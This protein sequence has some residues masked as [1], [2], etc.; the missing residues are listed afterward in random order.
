MSS[1]PIKV[2]HVHFWGDVRLQAGSVEKVIAAFALMAETD[3]TVSVACPGEGESEQIGSTRFHFFREDRLKNRIANKLLGLNLFT[4]SR[5]ANL[6][7]R[8]RP[9]LLHVHNRHAL[10]PALLARLS[11][12]P[13]VLCHY[14]RKFGTFV[15]PA[16]ADRLIAVSG[17]V[18]DALEEAVHPVMPIDVVYNPLP[19]GLTS[20]PSS[21]RPADLR[22]RLLFGGGRQHNKGFFELEA[23]LADGLA[24]QFDV[25]LCGP[26]FD[27][28]V[29]AFPARVLGLLPSAEFLAELRAADVV[30]MPSHH[31][32]FSILA[33]EA[34]GMGK[35]L[36]ATQGGGLGEIFDEHNAFIHPVGDAVGLAKC[37]TKAL[38]L[39]QADQ[40]ASLAARVL[41]A[42][43]TAA[44]FSPAAI[45]K[46]LAGVYREAMR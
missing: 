2:M 9:D 31:E 18:R 8:E 11:Y 32:G 20:V 24:E 43:E 38:G 6:I 12:R 10:L 19:P 37:L 1:K 45:N 34:L 40:S 30:A 7:E 3:I 27:G 35:V 23:A 15:V 44:R 46:T 17:A 42:K 14:H 13:R 39:F 25:V 4:F 36:V 29:P 26:A 33:L 41:A 16:E 5:L 28:Y 21:T 22:P